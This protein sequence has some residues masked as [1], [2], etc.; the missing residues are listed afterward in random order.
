MDPHLRQAVAV[1]HI[2]D[3]KRFADARRITAD[4]SPVRRS[5][6]TRMTDVTSVARAGA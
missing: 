6:S 3:L 1:A 5:L 4:G 2:D